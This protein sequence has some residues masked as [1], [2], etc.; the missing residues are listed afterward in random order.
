MCRKAPQGTY[1]RVPKRVFQWARSAPG[2]GYRT[3]W[4]VLSKS[5][6]TFR[7]RTAKAVWHK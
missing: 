3:L 6:W 4:D 7:K 2:E 1:Q 5:E